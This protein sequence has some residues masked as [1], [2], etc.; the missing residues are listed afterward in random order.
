MDSFLFF[1]LDVVLDFFPLHR[2]LTGHIDI[3]LVSILA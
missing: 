3:I 2:N 1:M